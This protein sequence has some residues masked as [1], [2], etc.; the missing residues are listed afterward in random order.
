MKGRIKK[1]EKELIL[2]VYDTNFKTTEYQISSIEPSLQIED[3]DCVLFDIENGFAKILGIQFTGKEMKEE[4][5]NWSNEFDSILESHKNKNKIEMK[6]TMFE[7]T[8]WVATNQWYMQNSMWYNRQS[9]GACT[10]S[11]EELFNYYMETYNK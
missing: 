11:T 9:E 1:T 7:F 2:L 5:Q 6:K 3:G 4:I 8:E 10:S